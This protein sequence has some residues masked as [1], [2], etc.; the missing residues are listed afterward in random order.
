MC[1][2]RDPVAGPTATNLC[3]LGTAVDLD[4]R[5]L[6]AVDFLWDGDCDGDTITDGE[7]DNQNHGTHVSGTAVGD[8]FA[9]PLLHDA[10]DGMAP[11]ARLVMQDGGFD[12]FDI[13][14]DLPGIGCPVVDLVPLF[15]QTYDQGARIHSNS[16]GD[17]EDAG[18]PQGYSAGSQDADQFMWDHKDFLLVFAAGNNGP[19]A[20]TVLSPSNAKSVVA[21]GATQRATSAESLAGFSSCGPTFDGRIKPEVTVPGSSIISARNDSNASS[22]NC[23]TRTL[24]GTSM[25]T[26]GAAGFA[27]LVR[28]YFEDG[29]YPS[30]AAEP[31]DALTPSAA[32]LRASLVNSAKSMANA[33]AIPG[34]CQGWGRVLLEDVLYF[35]GDDRRLWVVDDA[36][37]FAMGSSG[38]VRQWE[39]DVFDPSEPLEIT[40][41]WT[42]FPSTPAAN[43][44]INN[45]L[46]LEVVGPTGLTFR[47]N[48]FLFGESSTGGSADRLNTLEQVFLANPPTG[49]YT[50]T[51]R[52]FN[53]PDGPQPF[54]LLATGSV[55]ESSLI[56]SDGFES[57]D[58]SAWQ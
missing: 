23:N 25:S 18:F 9:Q 47:G 26:P 40:L 42:D 51:V 46:D 21:V 15:Q 53:V 8:N 6:I 20:V 2:F 11:G 1:Y 29:W 37:G 57:G 10:G 56:F 58:T 41:A 4:Q 43:P 16:W 52:S 24:S 7:W 34:G 35:A 50:V 36:D 17:Q 30:G 28:Q 13:C 31:G 54:A 39:L 32:L 3:N 45:D 38:E 12:N 19:G 33:P 22:D 49:V 44:T 48:V 14:A 5:K 27:A 55:V